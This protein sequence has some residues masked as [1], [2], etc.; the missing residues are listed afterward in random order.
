MRAIGQF[1]VV[2]LVCIV[3]VVGVVVV[4]HETCIEVVRR[5]RC[6]GV[7]RRSGVD[8]I[9]PWVNYYIYVIVPCP[10]LS[11]L[12]WSRIGGHNRLVNGAPRALMSQACVFHD[13]AAGACALMAR[14]WMRAGVAG[15]PRGDIVTTCET[16]VMIVE[17]FV[18]VQLGGRRRSHCGDASR[19]QRGRGHRQWACHSGIDVGVSIAPSITTPIVAGVACIGT[20]GGSDGC[21]RRGSSSGRSR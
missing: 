3:G 7:H 13:V 2:Y 15:V 8:K 14:F 18:V 4:G 6:G 20:H 12:L 19:G 5:G 9:I 10:S 17:E 21:W 16:V 1:G 11:S